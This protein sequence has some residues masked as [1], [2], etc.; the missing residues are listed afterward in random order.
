MGALTQCRVLGGAI[1]IGMATNLVNNQLKSSLSSILSEAQLSS[2]FIQPTEAIRMLQP[3]LQD[4][5]RMAFATGYNLQTRALLGFSAAEFLA[6][7]LM[8]ERK[9]R[10]TA[11]S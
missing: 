7:A 9:P 8:W 3:A 11:L 6:I 10:M 4:Q 2:L 1:G 5:V